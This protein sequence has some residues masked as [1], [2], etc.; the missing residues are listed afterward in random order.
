MTSLIPL[1]LPYINVY[2]VTRCYGGSDHGG[3]YY[4]KYACVKSRREFLWDAEWRKQIFL[5]QFS[6]LIWGS[7]SAE[8]DGQEVIVRIESRKAASDRIIEPL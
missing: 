3:W 8:S 2:V 1:V 6:G 4:R 5:K 7:I